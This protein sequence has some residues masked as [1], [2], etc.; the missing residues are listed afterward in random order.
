MK[1]YLAGPMTGL[2]QFNFPLFD[3]MTTKLR[4]AGFDVVSPHESDTP[5]VQ[6]AAWASDAGD[7][8]DLPETGAGADP[9]ETAIKNVEDIAECDGIALLP[10]W[11]KSSGTRHEIETAHRWGKDVA[12]AWLWLQSAR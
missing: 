4:N 6:A 7:P 12:P 3:E 10:K 1:L 9:L 5:E 2:P 11:H 8:A